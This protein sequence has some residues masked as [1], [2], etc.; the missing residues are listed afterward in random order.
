MKYFMITLPIG[1]ALMFGGGLLWLITNH[2]FCP[3]QM[4]NDC[5]NLGKFG[6]ASI[7]FSPFE[8]I[9]GSILDI[10]TYTKPNNKGRQR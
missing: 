5:D 1:I 9:L 10:P 4:Y 6:L 2:D 7:I 3:T 8:I